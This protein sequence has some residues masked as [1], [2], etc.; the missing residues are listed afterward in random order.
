MWSPCL[1]HQFLWVPCKM[2]PPSQNLF[3][4]IRLM[5]PHQRDR[6]RVITYIM[7]LSEGSKAGFHLPE[8]GLREQEKETDLRF[9]V[10]V[11]KQWGQVKGSHLLLFSH[12]VTSDSLWPRGWQHTRPSWPSLSSRVCPS[13]CPL[14]QRCHPTISSSVA[15]SPFAFNLS[16]HQWLLHRVGCLQ[17]EAKILELQFQL[18]HQPFQWIF[19]VD[20]PQDGLVWSPCS[21]RNSQVFSSTTAQ[22]HQFF[23]TAF[24]MVQLS[25]LYMTIGKTI[26]LN[27]WTFV[28]TWCLCFLIHCLGFS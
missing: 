26:A 17:Q 11:A 19:R 27:T 16:Q 4:N 7:R 1:L 21:P 10:V 24:F 20:F 12:Q 28:R 25:H 13:S 8:N 18:Q 2:D 15:S 23:D 9:F 5:I 6:G 14:S 3:P 22:K